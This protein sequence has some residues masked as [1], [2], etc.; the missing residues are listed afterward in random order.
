MSYWQACLLG[1]VQGIGEFLPISSSGHLYL[2]KYYL[3]LQD[4]VPLSFDIALHFATLLAVLT[5]FRKKILLLCQALLRWIFRRSRID[6]GPLLSMCLVIF[7]ATLITGF[8]GYFLQKI[9]VPLMVVAIGFLYTAILL[10]AMKFIPPHKLWNPV[11]Q[12]FALGIFQAIAVFPGIS[13]SGSTIFAALLTGHKREE[14]GE[15]S[16][17]LSIPIILGAF[18]FSFKDLFHISETIT[19]GPIIL[20]MVVAFISGILALYFLLKLIARAR[21]WHFSLYLIILAVALLIKH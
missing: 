11:S 7:F 1:L 15:Y 17:I 16:F 21:L 14:A 13:R 6:D 4:D 5:V 19:T 10:I 9:S 20:G 3:G 2:A 12:I 18:V 8:A